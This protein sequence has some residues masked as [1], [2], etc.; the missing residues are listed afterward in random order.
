MHSTFAV[1]PKGLPLEV[2]SQKILTREGFRDVGNKRG[3]S[4]I[5]EIRNRM[6]K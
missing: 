6:Q 4:S 5:E 1:T 3:D 2:L